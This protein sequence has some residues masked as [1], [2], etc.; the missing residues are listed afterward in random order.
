M[1]Q[2][3]KLVFTFFYKCFYIQNCFKPNNLGKFSKNGKTTYNKKIQNK[4][5]NIT[6]S[7]EKVTELLKLFQSCNICRHCLV[8][9]E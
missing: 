7:I 5:F 3:K 4:L 1:I 6:I 9:I 2:R 8:Q